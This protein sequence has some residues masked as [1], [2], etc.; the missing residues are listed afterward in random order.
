MSVLI[1]QCQFALKCWFCWNGILRICL[2]WLDRINNLFQSHILSRFFIMLL[3]FPSS[4][5]LVFYV[6]IR[7]FISTLYLHYFKLNMTV[8]LPKHVFKV[9][10]HNF[11]N[12]WVCVLCQIMAS[13]RLQLTSWNLASEKYT[14]R[15]FWLTGKIWRFRSFHGN[16]NDWIHP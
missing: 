4:F 14:D 15:K 13:E 6:L 3:K 5:W 12:S 9:S 11:G 8:D 2:T 10:E 16:I 1:S 7:K